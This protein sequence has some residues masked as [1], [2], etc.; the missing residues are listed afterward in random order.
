MRPA[1]PIRS[2]QGPQII[3]LLL[4]PGKTGIKEDGKGRSCFSPS[5]FL[6]DILRSRCIISGPDGRSE[7]PQ[8]VAP[9]SSKPLP[10]SFCRRLGQSQAITLQHIDKS[11][12]AAANGYESGDSVTQASLFINSQLILQ[13]EGG[14]NWF[15]GR[16]TSG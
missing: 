6:A 1:S 2:V 13:I 9:L 14:R 12:A 7:S 15:L 5:F 8:Q 10:L 3:G 11:L 16:G 4:P